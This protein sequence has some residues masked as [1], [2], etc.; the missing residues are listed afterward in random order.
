M[1]PSF[2]IGSWHGLTV[3]RTTR[4][5][6]VV[7]ALLAYPVLVAA[8]VGLQAAGVPALVWGAAVVAILAVLGAVARGLYTWQHSLANQPDAMLDERQVA[9]R[10]RAYLVAYRLF[11]TGVTFSLVAIGVGADVLDPVVAL[12]FDTVQPFF[13]AATYYALVLPSAAVAWSM[14]EAPADDEPLA[15]ASDASSRSAAL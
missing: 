1:P 15:A 8:W 13:W 12:S 14:P 2:L 6:A 9:I 7:V 3:A 4:R 11:A 10:D 5:A